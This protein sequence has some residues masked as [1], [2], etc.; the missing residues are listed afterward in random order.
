MSSPRPGEPPAPGG[1]TAR[2]AAAHGYRPAGP[3]REW[4]LDGAE[5]ITEIH[6]PIARGGRT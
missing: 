1:V 3:I 6:L 4:Y 5:A 2:W